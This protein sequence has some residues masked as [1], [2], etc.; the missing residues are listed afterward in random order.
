MNV[1]GEFAEHTR[2]QAGAALR[3]GSVQAVGD[4][5]K[6]AENRLTACR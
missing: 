2:A 3:H 4:R 1:L 6:R 5:D